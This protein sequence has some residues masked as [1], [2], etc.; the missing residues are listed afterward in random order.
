MRIHQFSII[1]NVG[2]FENQA[3]DFSIEPRYP[4]IDIRYFRCKY[5]YL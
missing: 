3:F 4:D 5:L 1:Q 2:T